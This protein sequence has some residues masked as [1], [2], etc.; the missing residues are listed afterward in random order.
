MNLVK[1]LR[2]ETFDKKASIDTDFVPPD[3]WHRHFISLLGRTVTDNQEDNSMQAYLDDNIDKF[4][5]EL[6]NP[7]TR[8][9][10]I[11][12]ISCLPNNKSTAFDLLSN[13]IL[14]AAKLVIAAP[15]VKLFNSILKSTFFPSKWKMDI[16]TPLHKSYIKS[17][18]NNFRGITVSSCFGK[19]FNKIMQRRLDKFCTANQSIS[20]LQGSGKQGSRTSD[21]LLIVR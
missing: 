11:T 8:A 17:E 9:E 12:E 4:R 20:P 7:I 1:S 10:V 13:E 18:P 15:M 5:S 3:T 16:L 2:N 19:L 14:K 6:D 21:H